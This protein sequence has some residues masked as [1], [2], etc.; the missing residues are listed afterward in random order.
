MDRRDP[1]E[2]VFVIVGLQQHRHARISHAGRQYRVLFIQTFG[3][4]F[5]W[6]F[7]HFRDTFDTI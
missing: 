6:V 5:Y 4:C 2:L 3:N 7:N 1:L